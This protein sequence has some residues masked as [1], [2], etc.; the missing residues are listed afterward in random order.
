MLLWPSDRRLVRQQKNDNPRD[1]DP[2]DARDVFLDHVDLPRGSERELVHDR[3][4]E[5]SLREFKTALAALGAP[6]S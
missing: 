6:R 4:R 2:I 5:Y 3:D 1:R